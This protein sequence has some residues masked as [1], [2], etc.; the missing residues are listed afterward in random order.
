MAYALSGLI[1][2]AW[3]RGSPAC[4]SKSVRRHAGLQSPVMSDAASAGDDRYQGRK[5]HT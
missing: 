1:A 3:T 4:G 5:Y 2:A